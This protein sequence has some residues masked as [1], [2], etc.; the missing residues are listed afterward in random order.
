MIYH[1]LFL[2][3]VAN[4]DPTAWTVGDAVKWI[5]GLGGTSIMAIGC[6][7]L[8]TRKLITPYELDQANKRTEQADKR[9]DDMKKERDEW[10]DVAL[11]SMS[12]NERLGRAAA[13]TAT[14]MSEVVKKGSDAG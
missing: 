1:I 5:G 14:V 13:Q 7:L 6:W 8:M 2:A 10:K 9:T 4:A 11:R 12:S 3:V